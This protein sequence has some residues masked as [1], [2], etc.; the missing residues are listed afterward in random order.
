M[1]KKLYN[2][3]VSIERVFSRLKKDGDGKL[4]NHRIR[5]LGKITLNCMLSVWVMQT[6]TL[7]KASISEIYL[8]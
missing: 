2:K 5:G 8:H 4:V 6:R 3:R 1:W 7:A